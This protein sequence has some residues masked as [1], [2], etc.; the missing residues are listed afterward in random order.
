MDAWLEA[1]PDVDVIPFVGYL[2]IGPS[3]ASSAKYVI[4]LISAETQIE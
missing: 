2:K 4:N 1:R 3:L